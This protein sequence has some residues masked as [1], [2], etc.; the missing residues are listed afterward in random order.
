MLPL[1]P[2]PLQPLVPAPSPPPSAALPLMPAP[3]PPPA[4]AWGVT[5]LALLLKMDC[6]RMAPPCFRSTADTATSVPPGTPLAVPLALLLK[7][8]CDRMASRV[9]EC[10]PR[11]RDSSDRKAMEAATESVS[12][13]GSSCRAE[14][15]PRASRL[16]GGGG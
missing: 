10:L 3:P 4:A 2:T 11:D 9:R 15:R 6:D 16:R 13:A 1:F 5:P 14:G 8:D 7:M 12:E